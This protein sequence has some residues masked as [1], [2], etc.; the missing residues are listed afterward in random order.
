MKRWIVLAA[1]TLSFLLR[2]FISPDYAVNAQS[3]VDANC[4][5]NGI[6]L[7]GKVQIVEDFADIT[8]KSIENFADLDVQQVPESLDACGK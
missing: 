7:H 1:F 8:V 5:Y 6:K 4:T 3:K 2:I